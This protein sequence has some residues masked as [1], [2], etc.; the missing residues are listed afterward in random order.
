MT[1][2]STMRHL[3]SKLRSSALIMPI[4]IRYLPRRIK[5]QKVSSDH[6]SE[7][8]N[9]CVWQALLITNKLSKGQRV[10]VRFLST[11]FSQDKVQLF[12]IC[13]RLRSQGL[14]LV[15]APEVHIALV[16]SCKPACLML[17]QLLVLLC[18]RF[19]YTRRL[20]AAWVGR[21]RH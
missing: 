20:D 9:A 3:F 8:Y 18:N 11:A 13:W 7:T 14:N 16:I 6:D 5:L 17:C 19:G 4:H 15:L 10:Q 1:G 2:Y 21:G 12:L